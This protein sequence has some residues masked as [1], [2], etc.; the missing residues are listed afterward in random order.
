VARPDYFKQLAV[1]DLLFLQYK[2]PQAEQ[3]VYL[4]THFNQISFTLSGK[5]ILHHGTKSWFLTDNTSLFVRK[6]A[7]KQEQVHT[8]GWEILAFYFPDSFL[9]QFF[10][11]C[12]SNLPLRNLPSPPSDMLISIN[13]DEATRAFFYSII[14]YFS[15]KTTPSENLLELK[16]KELLYIILSNPENAALLA[17]VNSIS[18]LQKPILHETMEANFMYNLS[19]IDFARMTQRSLASFKRDFIEIYHT[20]PG[21]WLAQ[22]KL[23]YAMLLLNTSKKNVTEIAFDSGFESVT[24]FSRVFKDKFGLAPLRYRKQNQSLALINQ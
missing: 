14:P 17:Y 18:D 5:K 15:Q 11:G 20:S 16:F 10:K 24:H 4:F 21:K 19:L 1:K 3:H 8:V 13:V 23:E 7:Y 22:K 12:K 6:T 9:Q 2:C